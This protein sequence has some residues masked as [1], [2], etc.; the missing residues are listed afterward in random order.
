M[1]RQN[2]IQSKINQIKEAQKDPKRKVRKFANTVADMSVDQ[3]MSEFDL[4]QNK[5]SKLNSSERSFI[6]RLCI[7]ALMFEA[8]VKKAQK[9]QGKIETEEP[10]EFVN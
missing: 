3:I 8:R 5:Q 10:Q 1:K 7:E 2:Y 6:H 4:I 9:K